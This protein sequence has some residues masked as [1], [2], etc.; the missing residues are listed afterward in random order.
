MAGSDSG[1]REHIREIVCPISSCWLFAGRL[2]DNSD[3]PGICSKK[4]MML[5]QY[6]RVDYLALLADLPRSKTLAVSLGRVAIF[7]EALWI[8]AIFE[9]SHGGECSC[10][11]AQREGNVDQTAA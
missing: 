10:A 5:V 2:L 4:N 1:V 3:W 6:F 7:E 9:E 11:W 8:L